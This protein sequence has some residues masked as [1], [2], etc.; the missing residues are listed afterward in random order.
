M[1]T[2]MPRTILLLSLLATSSVLCAFTPIDDFN[3]PAIDGSW[4]SDST[5]YALHTDNGSLVIAYNRNGQSGKWDQFHW[6]GWVPVSDDFAIQ[7]R[8]RSSM[9]SVL[10]LKLVFN[11]GTDAWIDIRLSGDGAWSDHS[12]RVSGPDARNLMAVYCYLDAGSQEPG[13][14]T[15]WID[16]LRIDNSADA[17]LLDQAIADA[18]ALLN[19]AVTGNLPGQYPEGAEAALKNAIEIAHMESANPAKT[20]HS[21]RSAVHAINGAACQFEANEIKELRLFGKGINNTQVNRMTRLLFHNLRVLAENHILFGSQDPTGYGVGWAGDNERSD[22]RTI[23]GSY[24]AIAS[25]SIKGVADGQAFSNELLR[26]KL[27]HEGGGFNTIEWHMD[28]PLGGDFYWSNR[29]SN[30]NAVEA[31]L[32]GGPKH[33]DF[34]RQLDNIAFFLRNLR[35]SKGR[36]IPVLFRPFHEHNG[37]WFWWGRP[38][39]TEAQYIALYQMVVDYLR[40]EKG[41]SNLLFA[42]SP[43]RSRMT[44][45]PPSAVDLLYGYPGDAYID[46]LGIDNYWDVG[47][48]SNTRGAEQRQQDF[49]QSLEI[50]VNEATAR[51]KIAA[52]TETGNDRITDPM[53]FTQ[54]LLEPIKNHPVARKLAYVAIWR[55]A[56]TSHHYAP[57]PGHPAE[58][59][60]VRFHADPFT[61]FMDRMPD[62]YNT[63]L[64]HPWEESIPTAPAALQTQPLYRFHRSD[65]DS[66][67]FTAEEH[68]KHVIL[69]E[70]P[71]HVW[72]LQGISHQ[73]ITNPVPFSQPVWRLYNSQ[74]GSHFYSMSRKEIVSVLESMG[75]FFILEG[76]AFRALGAQIPGS[77][78]VY[79]F[80]APRTASHFFTISPEERDH[81]VSSI[82]QDRLNYEGVA[83]FAFP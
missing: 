38:H 73:V 29:T 28:N 54:T 42:F 65:N 18:Q 10:G 52:L 5:T 51:G 23:T 27:F 33:P 58:P 12:V 47:H 70:L 76:I 59:D 14:G 48:P 61:V 40:G 69:T 32:P 53:W 63:L 66:H 55:N 11:N 56:D 8:V 79:R 72:T 64:D 26:F 41:V 9:G 20:R 77:H 45:N 17:T 35:D 21:I 19:H 4:A 46:I 82:P 34:L 67:F 68:E 3:L 50:L 37:D 25:W 60:F 31:I 71:E 44:I 16:Y 49:L 22:I 24:P 62:L 2:A 15:V 43:D 1:E 30:Q 13:A 81:I 74:A 6:T 36:S 80:Y 78:P 83:W 75:D 39:C 57:Y 7:A